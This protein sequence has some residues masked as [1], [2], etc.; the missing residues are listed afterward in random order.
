[1]ETV[2]FGEAGFEVS[3]F[4]L[5]TWNMGGGKGW[6]PEE[7]RE[8]IDLI[9]H[10]IETG[11]TFIDTARGYG[12]AEAVLGKALK[13]RRDQVRIATKQVHCTPEK[14]ATAVETSRQNLQ[15]DVIDLYICHWPSPSHSLEA[16][17]EELAR[18]KDAGRI[19]A[20][21]VSNFNLEQ[22]QVA[23]RYGAVSLQ[24]PFSIPWRVADEVMAFCREQ[25]VAVTPYSP[26]AQGLLTGRYSEGD[27]E[28][29]G[30]RKSN[31]L[32]SDPIFPKAREVAREVDRVAER[33]GCQSS[34]VALAWV[35]QTP[36]ITCPI[37]GASRREQWDENRK[38][39][40]LSLSDEDYQRLDELGRSVWAL[41][42]PEEAMWGW[43]PK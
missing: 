35:L 9:H 28:I 23:H 22:M 43:K 34:Q 3:R 36:G 10:A 1:M 41:V 37:M 38:A 17:F 14:L 13:G 24:P 31:L 25:N 15:T 42:D 4:C 6:G 26:L 21:G 40:D 18:Q 11:C 2:P 30:P 12:E 39:L 33:M 8:A 7:E 20:I 16:F 32:F 27:V 29:T 19:H 5:G